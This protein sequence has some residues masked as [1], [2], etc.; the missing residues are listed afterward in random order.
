[1][2]KNISKIITLLLLIVSIST[3][4]VAQRLSTF[5]T[6]CSASAGDYIVSWSGMHRI[7]LNKDFSYTKFA[8]DNTTKSYIQ[9]MKF[10]LFSLNAWMSTPAELSSDTLSSLFVNISGV[11]IR[12]ASGRVYD[13]SN[14]LRSQYP[15]KT[16][17][18]VTV[19]LD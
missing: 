5:D 11:Y 4:K 13:I 12:S 15:I 6:D 18:F 16:T 7:S 8:F 19:I 1:M 17:S 2:S 9:I 14:N 10:S 3:I